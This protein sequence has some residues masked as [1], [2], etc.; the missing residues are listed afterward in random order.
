MAKITA[1]N[2]T[3]L[4]N[5]S[6]FS[7]YATAYEVTA[8]VD[9]LDAT[10]FSDECKN[11]IPGMAVGKM[12][13]DM[14]WDK[15]TTTGIHPK[16]YNTGQTGNVTIIPEAYVLGGAAL[17]LPY[18]QTTY[19]PQ[20]DVSEIIKIGTVEFESYGNNNGLE[21]CAVLANA[22]ITATTTGSSVNN[23]AATTVKY[24]A[25]LHVWTPT[26]TDTYVVKVQHSTD[27]S[28][29]AD[30][31]AFT[32]NG[33]TITSERLTGTGT[34]NQYRRVLATRTGAAADPFG[35]TVVLYAV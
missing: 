24:A 5:G 21:F 33:K 1:K 27:N 31:A 25:V 18:T 16:L 10:G 15:T 11:Y 23:S 22:T 7:T 2:A 20:A 34:V 29:W 28:T 35:F 14:M 17:S 32:L 13:L 19:G 26:S 4:I 6:K 8:Q 3:V 9:P 30:L 12:T